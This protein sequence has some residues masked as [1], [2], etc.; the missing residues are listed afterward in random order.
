MNDKYNDHDRAILMACEKFEEVHPHADQPSWLKYCMSLN[1]VKNKNKNWVI[2]FL[3]LPKPSIEDNQYWEWEDDGIPLL[4]EVDSK[5]N[6]KSIVICGGTSVEPEVFFE[7][8]IDLDQ[9]EAIILN[10]TR[11]DR[12]DS[13][14][15]EINRR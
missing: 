15:Y 9:N 6:K 5:T 13:S 14:K 12:L 3:I 7:V 11:L 2:K 10:D 1:V 8:E 4:I